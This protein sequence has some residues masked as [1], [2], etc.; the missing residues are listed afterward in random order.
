M[1]HMTSIKLTYISS[2][3]LILISV[4]SHVCKW[5]TWDVKTIVTYDKHLV[6]IYILDV[7]LI[8]S[9]I[10]INP[11]SMSLLLQTRQWL[12]LV[13]PCHKKLELLSLKILMSRA[14]IIWNLETIQL[15]NNNNNKR[16]RRKEMN[17]NP[18]KTHFSEKKRRH[19]FSKRKMWTFCIYIRTRAI[20]CNKTHF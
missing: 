3:D 2:V 16:E 7:D 8:R 11:T 9:F 1:Q 12:T 18:G 5:D 13:C 10:G 17:F 19:R 4:L 14:N 15:Y 6:D 20:L